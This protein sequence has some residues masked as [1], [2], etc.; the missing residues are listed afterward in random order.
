MATATDAV[1][2]KAHCKQIEEYTHCQYAVQE[3]KCLVHRSLNSLYQKIVNLP[4]S[5]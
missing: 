3:M 5:K 1:T 2:L 4:H